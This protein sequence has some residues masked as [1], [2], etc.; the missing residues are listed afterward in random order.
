M[1]DELSKEGAVDVAVRDAA[2]RSGVGAADVRVDAAEDSLFPNGA[3]G[4][5][6]EGEVSFSM[7]TPGWTILLTA[8]GRAL[9]YRADS[10]QVR[11]VGVGGQNHLIYPA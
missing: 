1:G 6:R 10:Q 7:M 5:P 3:L 9:E 8:G 11:L 2:A 4:A